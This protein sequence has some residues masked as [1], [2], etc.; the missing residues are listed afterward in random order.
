MS[1]LCGHD[2]QVVEPGAEHLSA[3]TQVQPMMRSGGG[4]IVLVSSSVAYHGYAAHEATAA[5]K[6]AVN[7]LA[8]SAAN[9]YAPHNIRVNVC[10]PGLVR[11]AASRVPCTLSSSACEPARLQALARW[12]CWL[13][14]VR[15]AMT[16]VTLLRVP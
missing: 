15:H 10:S 9:T 2:M 8:L 5:A 12:R 11:A 7:G 6:G 1:L 3:G 16:V 13:Q 14:L 4:S